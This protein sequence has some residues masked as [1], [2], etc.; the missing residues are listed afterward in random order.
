MPMNIAL[1]SARTHG[2][3]GVKDW[4]GFSAS[5]SDEAEQETNGDRTQTRFDRS[6]TFQRISRED[7]GRWNRLEGQ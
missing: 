4:H 7:R 1:Y 6:P 5:L 3:L 2:H